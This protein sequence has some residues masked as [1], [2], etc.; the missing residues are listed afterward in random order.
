MVNYKKRKN[1]ILLKL[2]I[3]IFILNIVFKPSFA[4]EEEDVVLQL[5]WHHQ[6]QFAGYY[7]ANWMGYYKEEGLNVEIKPAIENNKSLLYATKEVKEGRA[8]FGIGSSDI[9]LSQNVEA[10]LCVVA[11]VFQRSPIEYYIKEGIKYSSVADI[12]K[13]KVGRRQN[14][15]LDIEMQA[16]LINEGINPDKLPLITDKKDFTIDDFQTGKYDILPGYMGA[17][18]DFYAHKEKLSLR[19][20]KP[21]DYGIDFY[22]DS[23]FTTKELANKNPEMVEKFRRASMKGWEYAINNPEEIAEKIANEFDVKGIPYKDFIEY[24]Q[25]QASKIAQL[26][27][28]P[29]V[30][31]GNVNPYRW[32]KM[33]E[34]LINLNLVENQIVLDEFVFNYNKI[35]EARYNKLEKI[36]LISLGI[37]VIALITYLVFHLI[38]RNVKLKQEVV[39]R[40]NAEDKI[41]KNKQRYEAI[42]SNAIIGITV[43]SKEG[44][45]MQANDKWLNMTGYSEIE[46]IGQDITIVVDDE[47][48][49]SVIKQIEAFNKDE[50]KSY[51][52]E[53]RYKRKNGSIWWGNLFMTSIYDQNSEKKVNLGMVV[54]ITNKKIEEETVKRSEQRFRNIIKEVASE[55]SENDN[56]EISKVNISDVNYF[57]DERS[58]LSLKLETINI[59]LEKMFKK[60]LD[61]NKRKEA[62][63]IY[64]ARLAAVGEM[65]ANIAHQWR[66]PLNNLALIISNIEDAYNYNEL[67]AESIQRYVS[68]SKKL[69][70]KMSETIDDFRD[71]SS[72]NS[73]KDYFSIYENINVLLE[74]VDENCRFNDI[75]IEFERIEMI[76]AYGY[77]NQYSQAVFNIINNSID[78]LSAIKLLDKKIKI[79]IYEEDEMAILEIIDNGGGIS[80]SIGDKIFDVYF[81]TKQGSN[82]TGLGLYMTKIIIEN[83]MN[84]KIDWSNTNNGVYMKVSI[85]KDKRC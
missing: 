43:T 2:F 52:M 10:N 18:I 23:L 46:V 42:F 75:K 9:L 7:A 15:L 25:Y 74:L 24:N 60:E 30:E 35:I 73:K 32:Q 14:D 1:K 53:R 20:I 29:I 81:T 71:F 40:K 22:G 72:P 55:I 41:L 51:E 69:I 76:E 28:Y 37:I 38:N 26:T 21:I 66:Q 65:I 58:K 27:L 5:R 45:I 77:A 47:D 13:L 64:Q 8:Q 31:I 83:N 56:Q 68:K 36:I 63:L 33:N 44:K 19:V 85:P 50:I 67:D 11:S 78:A 4:K 12:M 59:E 16:M 61:E 84:G 62:I 54:D 49:V 6:Y 34:V 70:S 3:V 48:D 17:M 79:S 57:N 39:E 80:E 82:G